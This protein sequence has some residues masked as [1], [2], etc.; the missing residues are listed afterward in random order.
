MIPFSADAGISVCLYKCLK[1]S[2]LY[3]ELWLF[4]RT[5]KGRILK[6][7]TY[8]PNHNT[9][10]NKCSSNSR[11]SCTLMSCEYMTITY[12]SCLYLRHKTRVSTGKW[13]YLIFTLHQQF[14][15]PPCTTH[16]HNRLVC[17]HNI[18]HVSKDEHIESYL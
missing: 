9:V 8:P 6:L 13:V 18:D 5:Y 10:M 11:A 16:L 14:L 4:L 17:R 3:W 15:P 1:D 7:T 2:T 12:T